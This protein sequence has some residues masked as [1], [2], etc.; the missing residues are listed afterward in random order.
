M[1]DG[2]VS[3]LDVCCCVGAAGHWHR[4]VCCW[5]LLGPGGRSGVPWLLHLSPTH[6][7]A[8]RHGGW[9]GWRGAASCPAGEE[10]AGDG[11]WRPFRNVWTHLSACCR[12][13]LWWRGATRQARPRAPH[14]L[15]HQCGCVRAP[16]TLVL[17][18]RAGGGGGQA[19]GSGW[20][21]PFPLVAGMFA[22]QEPVRPPASPEALPC[23]RPPRVRTD[24][25]MVGRSDGPHSAQV[26]L[27][28][29]TVPWRHIPAAAPSWMP[30]TGEEMCSSRRGGCGAACR[31][32]FS[33]RCR[34]AAGVSP[35]TRI[36]LEC[37]ALGWRHLHRLPRRRC[38]V[39][40]AH[41]S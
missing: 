7:I 37:N 36:L 8:P 9:V 34:R 17:L 38:Q 13:C 16:T 24:G 21:V 11:A 15:E 14:V 5:A 22:T 33:S 18:R 28:G 2:I 30:P 32:S 23:P 20:P 40:G 26:A 35:V 3:P 39:P 10:D 1:G 29:H 41:A 27:A 19:G 6:L 4:L 25:A 31:R 12:L